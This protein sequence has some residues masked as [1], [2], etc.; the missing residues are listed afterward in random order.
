MT[1]KVKDRDQFGVTFA[2][3]TL[4]NDTTRVKQESK[5]KV[6]SGVSLDNNTLEVVALR[7]VP[8]KPDGS[9]TET[10]SVRIKVSGSS[11]NQAAARDLAKDVMAATTVW[12]DEDV[13][14]GFDPQT[15]PNYTK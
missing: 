6:I 14:V 8:V 9:V 11:L 5:T 1:Q 4:P 2:D 10:L 7:A 12:L 13:F 15:S 3:P